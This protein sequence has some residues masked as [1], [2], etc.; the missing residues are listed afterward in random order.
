ML[1]LDLDLC[2][3]LCLVG[4]LQELWARCVTSLAY[5]ARLPSPS[6]RWLVGYRTTRRREALLG[7][8][9][10]RADSADGG[11][12]VRPPLAAGFSYLDQLTFRTAARGAIWRVYMDHAERRSGLFWDI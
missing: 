8:T 4:V 3:C 11:A 6:L 7:L 12:A 9:R 1:S 2:L 10:L 5:K